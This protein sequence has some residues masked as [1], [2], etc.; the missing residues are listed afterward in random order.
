MPGLFSR[1]S[2][3]KAPAQVSTYKGYYGA[4][5]S[6]DIDRLGLSSPTPSTADAQL[7]PSVPTK[8][9]L[10]PPPPKDTTY[11]PASQPQHVDVS[12]SRQSS[13]ASPSL[14]PPVS[15]SASM[16]EF[17]Q[18][19]PQTTSRSFTIAASSFPADKSY[20]QSAS[21]STL[22]GS[23]RLAPPPM[24]HT[25]SS[26]SQLGRP[27][28]SSSSAHDESANYALAAAAA[29]AA[30]SK[31]S[32]AYGYTTD[33]YHVYLDAA[34]VSIILEAC[35]EQIRNRG[36][37]NP[38]IFSSMALDLSPSNVASLIKLF[39][40]ASAGS[41]SIPPAFFDEIRYANPHDL[42]AFI[43]W[44][45]ARMGRVLAVPVPAP[46][47][48]KGEMR[49]EM[50]YVQQR[51]FLDLEVYNA[52]REQERK[53]QYSATAFKDFVS[54]LGPENAKLLSSLFSL[55]SSTASY[56]LK[57]GMMP[58]KLCKHFGPL[59]FGL[60]EDETFARTYDAYVRASNA[61]EHLLLAF[62]RFQATLATLPPRLAQHVSGYPSILPAE[63][64][65][66]SA[67]SKLVPLTQ[68]ERNVRLYSTDLVQSACEI[69]VTEPCPEWEACR[70]SNEALGKDP[71]LSDKFRKLIN[72]RGGA[73][74]GRRGGAAKT[75]DSPFE[76][77]DAVVGHSS[78]V[79]KQW[80]NFMSGGF[81]APDSSKLAFDLNESARRNRVTKRETVQWNEFSKDGFQ[82]EEEDT[83]ADVLSF[84]DVLKQDVQNWPS[85][86][87]HLHAKLKSRQDKLPAFN[88][89]TT[90]RLLASPTL[91]GTPQGKLDN[92]PISRMDETF[93][94]VWAD[95][96]LGNGWSNRDELTHRNASFVVVQYKSRPN[97]STVG[98]QSA[99]S[100]L[101]A[102]THFQVSAR[103]DEN[104]PK[105]ER[106]DAAW[107]VIQEVV[108]AQYRADLEA[109]GR[110]TFKGLAMIRKFATFRSRKDKEKANGSTNGNG[111]AHEKFLDLTAADDDVFRPGTGGT[112]KRILLSDQ[113]KRNGSKNASHSTLRSNRTSVD[114]ERPGSALAQSKYDESTGDAD[115]ALYGHTTFRSEGHQTGSKLMSTLR[116][117]SM[118][119][120][121]SARR[122]ASS[123]ALKSHASAGAVDEF[124]AEPASA[125]AGALQQ[126]D[127]L[128]DRSFTSADFETRSVATDAGGD[129]ADDD[130]SIASSSEGGA[131]K[132]KP[133]KA[134]ARGGAKRQTGGR[135]D[136]WI[137]ILVKSNG[138]R[139]TGQDA[140]APSTRKTSLGLFSHD[141]EPQHGASTPR[142]GRMRVSA[143][144][145][146]LEAGNAGGAPRSS[147]PPQMGSS[148]GTT[149]EARQVEDL[150]LSRIDSRSSSGHGE[151]AS[152]I[153]AD[154]SADRA[155]V[156][157]DIPMRDASLRDMTPVSPITALKPAPAIDPVAAARAALKSRR[158]T[159]ARAPAQIDTKKLVESLRAG[160]SPI[161]A[162]RASKEQRSMSP[163]S[164]SQSVELPK[165]EPPKGYRDPFAKDP[166]AGRVADVASR[167]GGR[168]AGSAAG[169]A[170]AGAGAGESGI[171]VLAKKRE[172]EKPLPASPASTA[173]MTLSGG[174][175]PSGEV[176]VAGQRTSIDSTRDPDEIYP[177]D[178][179]SNFDPRDS[180]PGSSVDSPLFAPKP[181]DGGEGGEVENLTHPDEAY[182]WRGR[183]EPAVVQQ[184]EKGA[185]AGE[186]ETPSRFAQPYQPGMPLDNVL[187]ESESVVSGYTNA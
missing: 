30:A 33:G 19:Q 68:I 135:D 8:D 56:S 131:A 127:V 115:A 89:D 46:G 99:G 183:G 121:K 155:D 37:D 98:S 17:G 116:A 3:A 181:L 39:T 11:S 27:T 96:L 159:P 53:Q 16:N 76:E 162:V 185:G 184:G 145:E 150:G 36:L 71:Q 15:G 73:L 106:V 187:E 50:V 5:S 180:H 170:G 133:S 112:T 103:T 29:A 55:L 86:R 164:P 142:M 166:V 104:G 41:R 58:A 158:E 62:I 84:D 173:N 137:D 65:L 97:A 111:S 38:L 157:S 59:L 160:L 75:L 1:R 171:P 48:K 77:E 134:K 4:V 167:F 66:P 12:M 13:R 109:S 163:G 40:S 49:E 125:G 7:L 10:P 156:S 129:G 122:G 18:M 45:F 26:R 67:S 95:Y 44:A 87:D 92:H 153:L 140:P 90:P 28:S 132:R 35:S 32:Y 113:L 79:S 20:L 186:G 102:P 52:W 81:A 151:P 69:D 182:A 105:D 63:M 24:L 147:T 117:K 141:V 88:Y 94:D 118:R 154:T 82:N 114:R 149:P 144:D 2:K 85:E 165:V 139:M 43:K 31:A 177:E 148:A 101:S 72:L 9:D 80:D 14:N 172:V 138:H 61:T 6:A 60:P 74:Q 128:A 51:G 25:V 119:V 93:A 78:L 174:A 123:P 21:T 143:S 23:R 110:G 152:Q 42:A 108:P 70:T 54:R 178:A 57:N 124:G 136:A 179:A 161:E 64:T 176:A 100:S 169:A 126:G 34:R 107:F 168:A 146:T 91:A 47:P 83:L 175:Q 130:A 22:G 120:V